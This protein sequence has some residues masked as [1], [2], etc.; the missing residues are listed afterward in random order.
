MMCCIVHRTRPKPMSR[1]ALF[2]ISL[3]FV[4]TLHAEVRSIPD[5]HGSGH[6]PAL[7][8][9]EVVT[10]G[11]VTLVLANGFWIQAGETDRRAGLPVLTDGLPD[12]ARGDR[13]R[14][15]GLLARQRPDNRPAD[16]AVTLMIEPEVELIASNQP[17][18]EPVRIGPDARQIP[19]R[20]A[21]DDFA[22]PLRPDD[23]AIDF[24]TRLLGMRV[25]LEIN[26]VVGP[27]SRFLDT[28]VVA[29][30]AHRNLGQ[31][32]TLAVQPDDFNPERI[33][34]QTNPQLVPTF[35]EPATVGDRFERVAGVVDYRFGNFRIIAE[36][37]LRLVPA[38]SGTL[39]GRLR[40]DTDH[41]LIASYNVENLNPVVENLSRVR[42]A[43]DVDDAI[44]SGRMAVLAQHIAV[45][46]NAP[47]IVAL[48]EVQDGDGAEDSEL[49]S[50]D[51]TLA[52]LTAA[53]VEAGGP[54]YRW[55]DLPPERNADGGQPGGNIRNPYLYNPD[56]VQVAEGSPT[57]IDGRAFSNSRKPVV[58]E[59]LFNGHQLVLINNHFAAKSGSEPLF[60]RHQPP[61]E[62]RAGQRRAQ[63]QAILRFAAGLDQDRRDRLIV[64]GDLNDHWFSAPLDILTSD[65]DVPLYNLVTDLPVDARFTYIFQ[66][67]AQAI[68]HLLVSRALQP[69][70]EL[71]ILH[72]NSLHPRQAS[73][74]DPLVARVH[75]PLSGH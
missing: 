70:S 43:R 65:H 7:A 53:I 44:G 40:G 18:P 49:V 6:E 15:R 45:T 52:A 22:G 54:E 67:N 20:L 66:G 12:V 59:F 24:W 27:T 23:N 1:T 46:M 9:Q 33:L 41:L 30:D 34:V 16:L 25:E 21:P 60:G 55:L 74:H 37:A 2:L 50:A 68:D 14:L 42:S 13:V 69:L 73:D 35:P 63:A 72:V 36:H 10:E 39:Q 32:G 48:Q 75:L 26:R 19:K 47:D 64:L 8:N 58:A 5:L 38:Q 3:L 56:R 28:W 4:A 51:R 29:D 61:E 57:R 71:E 31:F 11:V 62:R 17:L